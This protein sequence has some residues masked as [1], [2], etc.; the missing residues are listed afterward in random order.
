MIF[1]D[2]NTPIKGNSNSL[3]VARM[4]KLSKS[5]KWLHCKRLSLFSDA[6]PDLLLPLTVFPVG[7][8]IPKPFL[9]PHFQCIFFSVGGI[10][11]TALNFVNKTKI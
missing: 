6:K 9:V 2:L 3:L 11:P 1:D 8:E 5:G 4:G 10:V 7:T